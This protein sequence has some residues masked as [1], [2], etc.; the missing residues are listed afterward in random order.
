MESMSIGNLLNQALAMTDNLSELSHKA[1]PSEFNRLLL[2]LQTKLNET[3]TET[4]FI[5]YENDKLKKKLNLSGNKETIRKKRE[6]SSVKDLGKNEKFCEFEV[7]KNMIKQFDYKESQIKNLFVNSTTIQEL[8]HN[9]EKLDNFL[10]N[11]Q[12]MLKYWKDNPKIVSELHRAKKILNK[13]E[14]L[15]P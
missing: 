2:Q 14:F 15:A 8:A 4:Q 10:F 11:S 9:F 12:K 6:Q 5:L 3:K 7:I 1:S 13:G